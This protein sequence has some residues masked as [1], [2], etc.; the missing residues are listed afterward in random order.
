MEKT[1][2]KEKN[3]SDENEKMVVEIKVVKVVQS[4]FK[5]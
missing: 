2:T 5:E 3:K 1:Q 4:T